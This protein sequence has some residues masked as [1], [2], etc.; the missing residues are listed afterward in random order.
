MVE[1]MVNADALRAYVLE[2]S[3]SGRGVF[4]FYA[5]SNGSIERK[6][7]LDTLK[8]L[9]RDIMYRQIAKLYT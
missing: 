1:K 3:N 8:D 7:L 9:R 5:S 4:D 6:V 2:L